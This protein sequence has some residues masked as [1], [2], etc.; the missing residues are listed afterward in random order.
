[1]SS[2]TFGPTHLKYGRVS[3][4]N[5]DIHIDSSKRNAR[6]DLCSKWGNINVKGSATEALIFDSATARHDIK[7]DNVVIQGRVLSEFGNI[8]ATQST[9]GRVTARHNI[10][11][12]DSYAEDLLSEFGNI[13]IERLPETQSKISNVTARHNVKVSQACVRG[14]VRSEFGNVVANQS[15]LA[16]I[17]ARHNIDLINSSAKHLLSEFGDVRIK[18]TADIQS[19]I[20]SIK[21]RHKIEVNQASV[22]GK[23]ESEFGDVVVNQSTLGKV[24][25]R[26]NIDIIN[27]SATSLLSEFGHVIIRQTDGIQRSI[28][29]ITARNEI[30]AENSVIDNVILYVNPD[31]QAILDLTNTKVS[32]KIIIKVNDSFRKITRIFFSLFSWPFWRY[33]E[34]NLGN[35]PK[36]FSLLIKGTV[37]PEN[38]SFEGFDADEITS[39]MTSNGILVTGRKK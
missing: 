8:L 25:A 37:V 1:M 39:Q 2:F 12:V 18:Q 27:S 7:I 34:K 28:S 31:Q 21:A 32:E 26:H 4:S 19:Q 16:S 30:T 20:S 11:L 14:E 22:N 5:D 15:T 6:T 13:R 36:H 23:I 24:I 38:I 33:E 17:T 10:D 35:E 9:L 3:S 29:H